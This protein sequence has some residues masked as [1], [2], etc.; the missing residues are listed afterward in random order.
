M[1]ARATTYPAQQENPLLDISSLIDVSFLLLIFFLVT[2]TLLKEETDL[3][4]STAGGRSLIAS[5][6]PLRIGIDAAGVISVDGKAVATDV[7]IRE[8]AE[9][10]ALLAENRELAT[11]AGA[12]VSVVIDSA[13]DA[14]HQR[15]VDVMGA[16]GASKITHFAFAD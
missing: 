16:L 11:L 14:Q 9:L 13:D 15:L 7:T 2:S 1:K 3:N 10:R 5:P 12:Y 6:E 8:V 4:L